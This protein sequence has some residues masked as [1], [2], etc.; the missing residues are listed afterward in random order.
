MLGPIRNK[1]VELPSGTLLSGSSTENAGWR[2]HME[3]ASATRKTWSRT[4]P[5]NGAMEMAA[6][7]PTILVHRSDSI[8]VLS[9]TK[10]GRISEAWSE[11]GGETWLDSTRTGRLVV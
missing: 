11:D 8:Q 6:I 2:V 9:R 3:L 10:Q 7:Q 5:L 4:E 1:P